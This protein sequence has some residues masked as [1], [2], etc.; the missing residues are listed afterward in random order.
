MDE[1]HKAQRFVAIC[2]LG[3]VLFNYPFLALFNRPAL[4][5]GIPVF[6]VY[7]FTVWAALIALMAWVVESKDE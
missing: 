1:M 4:F 6:Y 2:L 5:L 7:L 3:A